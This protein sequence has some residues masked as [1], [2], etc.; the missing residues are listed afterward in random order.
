MCLL[1]AMQEL[2]L[3]ETTIF[4]YRIFATIICFCFRENWTKIRH[5][6]FREDQILRQCWRNYSL[7][8]A[9]PLT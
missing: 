4:R 8:A 9:V 1:E 6:L 2:E 5:F 7:V 3:H